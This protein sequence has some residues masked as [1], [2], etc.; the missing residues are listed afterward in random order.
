MSKANQFITLA[1]QSFTKRELTVTDIAG[2]KHKILIQERFKKTD[3][4]RLIEDMLRRYEY[5]AEYGVELPHTTLL[6]LGLIKY[7]TDIEF[8]KYDDEKTE[9]ENELRV[10]E[11][12]LDLDVL[13]DIVNAFE[14]KEMQKII[15]AMKT[16][17]QN[18]ADILEKAE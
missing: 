13:G 15:D 17:N 3:I 14:E 1:E 11:A 16:Y 5:C 7:F 4:I 10:Y 6:W 9:I 12:L 8:T 18:V 2:R